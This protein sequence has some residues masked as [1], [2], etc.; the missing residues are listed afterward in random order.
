MTAIHSELS[1][2]SPHVQSINLNARVVLWRAL[3][4]KTLSCLPLERATLIWKKP[5]S[6]CFNS[7][8]HPSEKIE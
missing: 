2:M 3:S 7:K 1:R 8:N 4:L 6:L 5:P